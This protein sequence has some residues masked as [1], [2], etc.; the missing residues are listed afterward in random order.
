MRPNNRVSDMRLPL[1][2]L[3]VFVAIARHG[4]L[5][6]AADV[7]GVKP[8]TVS[9]QL[10][11]LE[12]RLGTALFVRTTRSINPTEA[13]R[14]LL[15]GADPAFEQLADAIDS[16]RSSQ[17][18]ARGALRLS[19]P[20]FVYHLVVAPR[21]SAFVDAFPEIGLEFSVSDAFSDILGEGLHAGFR[22]GDRIAADM[23]AVRLTPPLR[24]AALAS[25]DYLDRRGRPDRP[26]ALLS[27][28]CIRYRFPTSGAL[29][30]WVFHGADGDLEVEV[31]RGLVADALPVLL[32]M[33]ERGLGLAYTFRDIA[34]TRLRAGRLEE[35]LEGCALT[36]PG[37]HIYFPREYRS[38]MALRVFLDYLRDA[39]GAA[40]EAV[41]R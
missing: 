33:A 32:D 23:V 10:K 19:I 24:L 2:S 9:H 4:T 16:A 11:A 31:G 6:A 30:P 37:I 36:V 1:Q 29:Y 27:H 7:L 8:S 12:N 21:L 34:D 26:D 39:P 28:S 25:P 40:P 17:H 15:R 18:E 5:R 38:M 14:A 35:V 3:E 20:E 13:G 41:V 22:L